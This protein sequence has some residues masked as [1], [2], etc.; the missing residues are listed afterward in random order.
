MSDDGHDG[1]NVS[2]EEEGELELED[3]VGDEDEQDG[4]HGPSSSCS[5][6]HAELMGQGASCAGTINC[7]RVPLLQALSSTC[8]RVLSILRVSIF[9]WDAFAFLSA[10]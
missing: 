9:V 4:T 10:R 6:A 7:R 5:S 8:I 1:V 3:K 2:D